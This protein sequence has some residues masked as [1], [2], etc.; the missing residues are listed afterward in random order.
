MQLIRSR[1]SRPDEGPEAHA[2]HRRHRAWPVGRVTSAIALAC[3]ARLQVAPAWVGPTPSCT[4]APPSAWADSRPHDA[5]F[6]HWNPRRL[7]DAVAVVFMV[8]S[9]VNFALY[10]VRAAPPLAERADGAMPSYEP[11][12]RCCWRARWAGHRRP[13]SRIG[14]YDGAGADAA[15]RGVQRG[16]GGYHHR[17]RARRL[18]AVADFRAGADACCSGC[19]G[20]PCAGSTGGGIKMVRMVPLVQAGAARS[21]CASCIRTWSTLVGF[22]GVAVDPRVM[23]SRDRLHDG[24]RGR[25]LVALGMVLVFSGLDLVTAIQCARGRL[26]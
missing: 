8:L 11:T 4:C 7:I 12:S 23:H 18:R 5:G 21:W 14:T 15:P 24:L 20:D 10:F 1:N 25:T 19:F 17:L 9:G 26:R 22:G 6:M 2:A 13:R 16:V 3:F